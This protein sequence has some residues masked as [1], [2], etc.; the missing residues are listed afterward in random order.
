MAFKNALNKPALSTAPAP[1][2][3][4]AVPKQAPIPAP[5]PTP[6]GFGHL[7]EQIKQVIDKNR[8]EVYFKGKP[9][10]EVIT[11]LK[12]NKFWWNPHD[13][14]WFN[15]DTADSRAFLK[16]YL[17]AD[18][19]EL[20][21]LPEADDTVAIPPVTAPPPVAAPPVTPLMDVGLDSPPPKQEN[22]YE[23]SAKYDNE[24]LVTF[25]RQCD[26]LLVQLQIPASDLFLVAIDA[27]H[28][29]TFPDAK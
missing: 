20:P 24:P 21:K 7:V 6:I 2:I 16:S 12:E 9:P 23:A 8:F 10:A 18:V 28:K 4:S 27:L 1:R 22:L 17:N 26:E 11:K 13:K 15:K 3:L 19:E 5:P 29:Q 25:R 14:Y